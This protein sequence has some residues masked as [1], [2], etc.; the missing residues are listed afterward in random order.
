MEER[1]DT[2]DVLTHQYVSISTASESGD[3]RGK[4]FCQED[5]K[6][7]DAIDDAMYSNLKKFGQV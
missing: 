2:N 1:F 3:K 5:T 4:I 7:D 6:D